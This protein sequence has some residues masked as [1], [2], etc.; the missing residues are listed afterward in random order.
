MEPGRIETILD[1]YDLRWSIAKKVSLCHDVLEMYFSI[2]NIVSDPTLID[3][4]RARLVVWASDV[5]VF[6]PDK[7]DI[8]LEYRLRDNSALL[9]TIHY[10]FD[11]I[12]DSLR[13]L[14]SLITITRLSEL[15]SKPNENSAI[16][17]AVDDQYS[18]RDQAQKNASL[19]TDTIRELISGLYIVRSDI[20]KPATT[21]IA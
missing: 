9:D 14:K 19:M 6:G 7:S 8:S 13:S 11:E 12:F 3:D 2:P 17:K 5:G 18:G 10:I 16:V 1:Q 15:E 21:S 4:Q 20:P